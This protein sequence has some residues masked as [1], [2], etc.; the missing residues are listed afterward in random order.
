MSKVTII[1]GKDR[2]K[3]VYQS[4]E[5]LKDEIREKIKNK[6]KIVIKPNFVHTTI[7]DS[8]TH[9]ETVRAVLD[10]LRQFSSQKITIAEGP[11]EGKAEDGYKN[12]G[13]FEVLKN[14]NVEF[15]DL[16]LDKVIEVNLPNKNIKTRSLNIAKTIYESDFRISVTLPKTHGSVIVTLALKNMVI[17]SIVVPPNYHGHFYRS[18]IHHSYEETNLVIYEL[19]K[20]IPPHLSII[21]GLVAM[22]GL[23][24]SHGNLVEMDFAA[25]GFD[26]L[27]L[28]TLCTYLMGFDPRDVGYLYLCNKAGLGVGDIEKIKIIGEKNWKKLQKKLKPHPDFKEQLSW[29]K[30][31]VTES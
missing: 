30:Y 7:Q 5:L 9:V 12:Y 28:D 3:N 24:P 2:Y 22:E 13:Y 16:N 20:V 8:A 4:L 31:L 27:A 10:F 25:S 18:N 14:Y 19:A 15:K 29:K 26:F 1:S 21:D 6:R 17:G 11:Y 23:G